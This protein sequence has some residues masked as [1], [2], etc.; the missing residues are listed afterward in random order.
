MTIGFVMQDEQ[1]ACIYRGLNGRGF[2]LV[3]EGNRCRRNE[4]RECSTTWRCWHNDCRANI[5][6]NLFDVKAHAPAIQVR[7]VGV[8][9]S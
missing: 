7:Q 3:H 2:I 4:T 6:T 1:M 9:K 5:V 8:G